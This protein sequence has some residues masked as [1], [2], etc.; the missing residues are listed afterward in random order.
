MTSCCRKITNNT[1]TEKIIIKDSIVE[2]LRDTTIYIEVEKIVN[3]NIVQNS[4]TS[5]LNN[6]FSESTAYYHNGFLHHKLEQKA[7]KLP[8]EIKYVDRYHTIVNDSIIYKTNTIE[9]NK[10][11]KW[12]NFRL[13]LGNIFGIALIL[14][15]GFVAFRMWYKL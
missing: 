14:L 5:V 11:T 9:V 10:L 1:T 2:R 7:Q 12:Q 4:D 6:K 3:N 13:V 8:I 15:V